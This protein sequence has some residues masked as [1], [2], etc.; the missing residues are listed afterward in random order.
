M[1]SQNGNV[2]GSES[3]IFI[4]PKVD[5][6]L[7]TAILA[8]TREQSLEILL[9]VGLRSRRDQLQMSGD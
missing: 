5:L 8:D 9:H 1:Q 7:A 6:K 3:I 4:D 2:E